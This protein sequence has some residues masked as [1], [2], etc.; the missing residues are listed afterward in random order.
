MRKPYFKKSHKCWYV[1]IHGKPHRLGAEKE[2]AFQEYH[3]LMSGQTPATPQLTVCQLF[4]QFL[5]WTERNRAPRT[6]DWYVAHL[7]SFAAYVGPKLKVADAKPHHVDSWLDRCYRTSGNSHRN[8]ACRAIAR[9]FNWAVKRKTLATSPIAGMER[10]AYEPSEDFLSPD[11]WAELIALVN[12]DDP[13]HD[14]VSLLWE[15]GARPQ[16]VRILAAKHF[17]RAGKRLV[18]ERANSKGKRERRVIRLNDTAMAIVERLTLKYPDGPL[19]RNRRGEPWKGFALNN[20]F[21]RLSKKLGYKVYAYMLRHGFCTRA[22]VRGVDPLT[23]AT[24][25]GHK[26]AAMVMKVYAHLV[27]NDEFLEEKLRQATG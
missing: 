11:Q 16:E 4:D 24:L 8:G 18:L 27:Q 26:S 13:F 19:L 20:R 7:S 12:P 3:R 14:Y 17:D 6:Y 15:T 2:A 9:A 10:P 25:M 22:L 21:A 1:D 5:N 23:V